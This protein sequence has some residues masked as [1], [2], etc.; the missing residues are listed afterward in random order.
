[1]AADS[2]LTRDAVIG[3]YTNLLEAWNRRDAQAFAAQFTES[4]S[5]VGFDGSQLDG[6]A[7]IAGELGRIFADHIPA[8]Y[9]GKVIEV[10][11]LGSSAVLLRA[12][13]GMKPPKEAE[14]KPERNAVQ[15]LVAVADGGVPKIA[16]YQN[17]P[18]R[19]DGRPQ[20]AERLTSDLTA[21][22]RSG[23]VVQE[24]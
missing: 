7:A 15:S 21:V 3:L 4:G 24:E 16:L 8:T 2:A 20:L 11:P 1:M 18:A 23:R 9:V 5:T 13:A 12:V 17:T 19:F 6:R 10:R 22:L 14:L